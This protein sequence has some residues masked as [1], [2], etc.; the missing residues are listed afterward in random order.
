MPTGT[1]ANPALAQQ[2]L[3][4]L[5]GLFGLHPGFRPAHAKGLEVACLLM[6]R[7]H[8]LA[9]DGAARRRGDA[10]RPRTRD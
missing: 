10:R 9:R 8:A 2:L 4:A 3:E 6:D 7:L 1:I 5:D